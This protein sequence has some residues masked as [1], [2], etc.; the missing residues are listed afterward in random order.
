MKYLSFAITLIAAVVLGS[1]Y[2]GERH[3]TRDA[4][5][6]IATLRQS[7]SEVEGRVAEQEQRTTSLQARLQNTQAK[8]V[9]KADEVAHLEQ[10]LTN[11]TE[12]NAKASNP[13]GEMFKS[14][15]IKEMVKNQQKNVLSGMIDKNYGSFFTA[16]KLTPELSAGLKDLVIKKSLVDANMGMSLMTGDADPAKRKEMLDQA[17]TEKEGIDAEIKQFLG[18]DYYPQ[19][20]AYEKTMPERM[21][22][23]TFKDQQASGPGALNPDQEAQLIQAMTEERQNFKFGTDFYDQSK[24]N[25]D[26]ASLFTEERLSQFQQEREQLDQ[27]YL[28]RATNILSPDQLAPFQKF[29]ASQREMQMVG[30][31]MGMKMFAPKA[32]K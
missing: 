10:V 5:A 13:F 25:G 6:T 12:T 14:P 17:K 23:S 4:E 21:T 30:M 29:L 11:R 18:E 16:L 27:Q 24:F 22:L 3:K 15:E 7:L 8:A 31:K 32:E 20:Q 28:S 2:I 1:L 19:F 26:F 9:A